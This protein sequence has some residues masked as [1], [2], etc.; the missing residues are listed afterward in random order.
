MSIN[1]I[2]LCNVG[3]KLNLR[4]DIAHISL[5]KGAKS[6]IDV[7]T[8]LCYEFPFISHCFFLRCKSAFFVLLADAFPI[9]V[10]DSNTPGIAFISIPFILIYCQLQSS[11]NMDFPVSVSN[12]HHADLPLLQYFLQDLHCI[13]LILNML[14]YF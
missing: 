13:G 3:T 1:D 9:L 10:I 14:T 7:F 4:L 5:Y 6:H 8:F 2:F 11:L 12:S